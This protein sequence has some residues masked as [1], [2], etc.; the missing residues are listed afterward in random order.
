LKKILSYI[1]ISQL[2]ISC[3]LPQFTFK[4][5]GKETKEIDA[6]TVQVDFFENNSSLGGASLSASFTED[7]RDIMQSQTKLNL[8]ANK[9]DIQIYGKIKDFSIS[10]INIQ[11]GSESAAQNRLKMIVLVNTYFN[12]KDSIGLENTS[13][14]AF[15]DYDAQNDFNSLEESLIESLNYQI[16]QDIF[17]K[18]F[19]GEW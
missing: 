13:F 9:G 18:V 10:P 4:S 7:L 17:D 14:N 16:T 8:V 12:K 5:G 3:S 6:E 19:G 11:S 15:V 2:I 1:I